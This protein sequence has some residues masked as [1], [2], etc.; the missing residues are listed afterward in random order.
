MSTIHGQIKYLK[1]YKY[2]LTK[3]K[4]LLQKQNEKLMD[5]DGNL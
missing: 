4:S 2:Q 3:S 1:V 5:K